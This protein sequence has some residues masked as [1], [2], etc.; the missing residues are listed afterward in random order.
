MLNYIFFIKRL[1]VAFEATRSKMTFQKVFSINFP[2]SWT[3]SIRVYFIFFDCFSSNFGGYFFLMNSFFCLVRGV[4][5]F[6]LF[7]TRFS[8]FF[9]DFFQ[10]KINNNLI[11]KKLNQIFLGSISNFFCQYNSIFE[12][13]LFVAIHPFS[14]TLES[15]FSI[16]SYSVKKMYFL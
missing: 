1:F 16:T 13:N 3:A 10:I 8:D 4:G 12:F 11:K 14:F 2:K 7:F 15:F 6:C 5:T 9:S